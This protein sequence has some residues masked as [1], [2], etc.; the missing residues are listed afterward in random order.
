M[1][2]RILIAVGLLML[3]SFAQLAAHDHWISRGGLKNAAGEWCCGL[4]DCGTLDPRSVT[5]RADGW[6]LDGLV[7]VNENTPGA[8]S[9]HVFETVPETEVQP[10]PDGQVWRCHRPDQSRRCFFAPP[11]GS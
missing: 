4:G 7:T 3:C 8:F 2:R 9:F 1:P 6:H 5:L 10:S 11:Q